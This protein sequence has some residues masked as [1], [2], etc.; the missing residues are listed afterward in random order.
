MSDGA[1]VEQVVFDFL[2]P[3]LKRYREQSTD[4]QRAV[5]SAI[6]KV[7]QRADGIVTDRRRALHRA[8]QALDNCM[9]Q[10]DAD[11][12]GFARKVGECDEALQRAVRGRELIEQGRA[13]FQH[14][15]K[16]HT[17]TVDELLIRAEKLVRTADERTI[18]YQ[19]ASAFVPPST[20]VSAPGWKSSSGGGSALGT[21][22]LGIAGALGGGAASP[23]TS[24]A[25]GEVASDAESWR[26]RPG[27]SVPASFPTGFALVPISLITNSNPVAGVADFDKGQDV[28]ALQWASE[29]FLDVVLPAMQKVSSPR[30]YLAERDRRENRTGAKSFESTYAGFFSD[31]T[32]IK[33]SPLSDGT[34]DL[35]NGRHRLWLLDRAGATHIAARIGGGQ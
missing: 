21:A 26:D 35:I 13:R 16:K 7:S 4:L 20:T 14:A 9:C 2:R 32:A 11:C 23:R 10:E 3:Q 6:S 33:L 31:Q 8:Q 24:G 1:K 18:Q 27:V 34:F 25:P 19:K 22:G 30:E 12:S 29:A 15:Q 28:A 5:A 17:N